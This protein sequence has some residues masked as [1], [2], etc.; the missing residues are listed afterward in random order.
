MSA[1]N[2]ASCPFLV[3]FVS[4]FFCTPKSFFFAPFLNCKSTLIFLVFERFENLKAFFLQESI[5]KKLFTIS[6]ASK[7]VFSLDHMLSTSNFYIRH[8]CHCS[9]PE[10]LNSPK[11][12]KALTEVQI[13][14]F[15]H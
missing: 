1:L 11:V 15:V 7:T 2:L 14:N 3:V 8:R 4:D 9:F 10:L 12:L 13:L 5:L 6:L